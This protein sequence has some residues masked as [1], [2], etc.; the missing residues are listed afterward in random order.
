MGQTVAIVI[1]FVLIA[2]GAYAFYK[3]THDKT[4]H[5]APVQPPTTPAP[6]GSVGSGDGGHAGDNGRQTIKVE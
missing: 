2:V 4:V 5:K 1:L 6:T 3:H